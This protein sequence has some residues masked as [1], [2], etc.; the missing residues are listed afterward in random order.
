MLFR[1]KEK[2]GQP[3][4]LF[5]QEVIAEL[6]VFPEQYN[7][8]YTD[9]RL[10]L[11]LCCEAGNNAL[12]VKID[13]HRLSSYFGLSETYIQSCV[14][15]LR[16]ADLIRQREYSYMINPYYIKFGR[17]QLWSFHF[18]NWAKAKAHSKTKTH[19]IQAIKKARKAENDE[20]LHSS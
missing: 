15:K 2:N 16:W 1:S 9:V 11:Y 3:F 19:S 6:I 7:L 17:K 18:V 20:N 14:N 4:I 8:T 10:F 12:S 5:R 13:I